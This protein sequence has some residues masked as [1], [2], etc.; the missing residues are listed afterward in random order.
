[1]PWSDDLAGTLKADTLEERELIYGLCPFML[2]GAETNEGII[3][4]SIHKILKL[5]IL[6]NLN[7]RNRHQFYC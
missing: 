2:I 4:S 7:I 5:C 6:V 1:M 3:L